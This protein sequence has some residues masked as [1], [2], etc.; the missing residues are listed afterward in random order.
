MLK[1]QKQENKTIVKHKGGQRKQKKPKTLNAS[2][3]ML[4]ETEISCLYGDEWVLFVAP[5]GGVD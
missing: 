1:L 4:L 3:K 5:Y 2:D